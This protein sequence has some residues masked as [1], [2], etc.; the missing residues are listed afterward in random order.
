M[1]TCCRRCVSPGCCC[2]LCE[3]SMRRGSAAAAP[4][5]L[6]IP[7][8]ITEISFPTAFR[9]LELICFVAAY[10]Q[11]CAMPCAALFKRRR[12][13]MRL[14]KFGRDDVTKGNHHK[15][16]SLSAPCVIALNMTDSTKKSLLLGRII[17]AAPPLAA[18]S[19][20]R[21]LLPATC[22]AR[23][24]GHLVSS[25]SST[26]GALSVSK[27]HTMRGLTQCVARQPL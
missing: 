15:L 20:R 24:Y 12:G 25:L 8:D 23:Q 6:C 17:G 4:V 26:V 11:L 18:F 1:H 27:S 10:S 7:A 19:M 3:L 21:L 22:S 2:R 9:E 16:L 5:Q 13:G 14:P